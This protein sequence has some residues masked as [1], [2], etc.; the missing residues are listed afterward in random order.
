MPHRSRSSPPA[1]SQC[2]HPHCS[3]WVARGQPYCARHR[4][5]PETA[6][7]GS[8]SSHADPATERVPYRVLLD[9]DLRE[10]LAKATS[11]I[12]EKGLIDELGAL[13]VVLLRVLVEEE[14]TPALVANIT[15]IVTVAA[16]AMRVQHAVSGE[17]ATTV[18]ESVANLI[19]NLVPEIPPAAGTP[20]SEDRP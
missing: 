16:Q 19:K 5:Q 3:Y 14:E 7:A 12:L 13:R 2:Q 20:D 17:Q 18:T 6:V 15:R 10:T 9:N 8:S 1:R 4:D 11:E